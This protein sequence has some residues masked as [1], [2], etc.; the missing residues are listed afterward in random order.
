[1]SLASMS[2]IPCILRVPLLWTRC[3]YLSMRLLQLTQVLYVSF[4]LSMLFSRQKTCRW[5]HVLCWS[6][7]ASRIWLLELGG[8]SL[9]SVHPVQFRPSSIFECTASPCSHRS[10]P[11]IGPRRICKCQVFGN[12]DSDLLCFGERMCSPIERS[13]RAMGLHQCQ[14]LVGALLSPELGPRLA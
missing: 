14:T 5:L 11:P 1:M 9:L 8:L 2:A 4:V 12:V 10:G 3:P 6:Q 13:L 7:W